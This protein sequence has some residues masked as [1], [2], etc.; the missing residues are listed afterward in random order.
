MTVRG[1]LAQATVRDEDR[2]ERWYSTLFGRPP[3]DR[4]MPGLLE[5]HFGDDAGL[6]VWTEADRAGHSTVVLDVDDLDAVAGHLRTIGMGEHTP[7]QARSSR[8][9]PIGDPDGNR[10]VFTGA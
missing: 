9:L 10:I 6:Q 8:I 3:D 7:G 2:A 5:W 1:V 4:P